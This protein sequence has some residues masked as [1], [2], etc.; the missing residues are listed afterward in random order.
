MKVTLY[1][2]GCPKCAVLKAKLGAKGVEFDTVTNTEEMARKGFEYLPMLEVDGV[3]YDF[4][5]AIKWINE[6]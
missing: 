6:R 4:A 5:K 2:T 1:T 3:I